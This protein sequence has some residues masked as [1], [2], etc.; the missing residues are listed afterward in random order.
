M[1][2]SVQLEY[3]TQIE[4]DRLRADRFQPIGS[5]IGFAARAASDKARLAVIDPL[6]LM[7]PA[8][9]LPPSLD[10]EELRPWVFPPVECAS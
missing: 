5:L 8:A 10:R 6:D 9:F 4:D 3:V 2:P 1:H 7:R